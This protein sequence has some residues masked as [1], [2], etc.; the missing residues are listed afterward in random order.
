VRVRSLLSLTTGAALGAGAMY[1]LDP[2]HGPT[3]RQEAR[4]SAYREGR[5]VAADAAARGV[6]E[7]GSMAEAAVYGFSAA[8]HESA[9]AAGPR[10]G[11]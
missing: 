5:R 2:D 10:S 8:R 6:R 7:L 4:R 3:R 11:R 9:P 1:L